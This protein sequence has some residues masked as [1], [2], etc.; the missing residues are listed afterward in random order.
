M[1]TPIAEKVKQKVSTNSAVLVFHGIISFSWSSGSVSCY[2]CCSRTCVFAD[3]KRRNAVL[4]QIL[5]DLAATIGTVPPTLV[6]VVDTTSGHSC[7]GGAKLIVTIVTDAFDGVPLIKRHRQINDMVKDD[8]MT[9][10]LIHALT[11]NTWTVAQYES[12]K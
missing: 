1:T 8:F 10:G 4:F 2:S 5:N 9:T 12:K 11:L 7:D 3:C 6:D